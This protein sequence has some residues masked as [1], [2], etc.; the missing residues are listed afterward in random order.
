MCQGIIFVGRVSQSNMQKLS[1]LRDNR[2]ALNGHCS[3]ESI[4]DYIGCHDFFQRHELAM[5]W[6]YLGYY[7]ACQNISWT[8]DDGNDDIM[9]SRKRDLHLW[10]LCED[11]TR[12]FPS[13]K[14]SIE[15][16]WCDI[17]CK[18]EQIFDETVR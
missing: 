15:K 2:A 3:Y 12:I 18:S 16:F 5:Y 9:T 4:D 13:R 7:L 8:L 11:L 10:H 6:Y 1:L 17:C 14:A